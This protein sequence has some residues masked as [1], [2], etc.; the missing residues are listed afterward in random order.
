MS[1]PLI[2][3]TTARFIEG[4]RFGSQPLYKYG[5]G[6]QGITCADFPSHMALPTRFAAI[7]PDCLQ[8]ETAGIGLRQTFRLTFRAT[9]GIFG[10]SRIKRRIR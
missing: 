4:A 9:G 7:L 1:S 5:Q 2:P 10:Q 6:S 8:K 3:Y